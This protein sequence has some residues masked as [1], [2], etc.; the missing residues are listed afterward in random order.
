MW[1]LRHN[2]GIVETL[3]RRQQRVDRSGLAV[4]RGN[5]RVDGKLVV[6]Q[7]ERNP[8]GKADYGWARAQAEKALT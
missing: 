3:D 2:T 4:E 8:N 1:R 7:I 6:P 5:D